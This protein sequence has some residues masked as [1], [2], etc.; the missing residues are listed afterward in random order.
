MLTEEQRRR[1]LQ[2]ATCAGTSMAQ[3]SLRLNS[4][5]FWWVLSTLVCSEGAAW[6]SVSWVA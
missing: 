4:S 5:E 6:E 2:I 1:A 3:N